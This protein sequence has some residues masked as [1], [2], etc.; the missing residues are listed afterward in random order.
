MMN[1][2][3]FMG[4]ASCQTYMNLVWRKNMDLDSPIWTV[5]NFFLDIYQQSLSAQQ[6][7]LLQ[8]HQDRKFNIFFQMFPLFALFPFINLPF[9]IFDMESLAFG[10]HK[11][12]LHQF[13]GK[14]PDSHVFAEDN[15][16]QTYKVTSNE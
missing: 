13:K 1:F 9:V 10:S 7:I 4:H 8:L 5:N 6:P 3:R 12:Y 14:D 15:I 2:F 16:I 11:E